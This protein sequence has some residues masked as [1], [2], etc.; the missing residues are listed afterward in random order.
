MGA[1]VPDIV[2]KAHQKDAFTN[3]KLIELEKCMIDPLYFIR[4]YVK[5]Q[6][7]TKGEVPFEPFPYQETMIQT[8]AEYS[9]CIF[10]TGRQQGKT[11]TSNTI[12]RYNN[13]KVKI[14][15][16]I[17]LTFKGKIINFLENILLQLVK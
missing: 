14:K 8:C 3:T 6:H 10:L 7:P 15:N 2:K 12:I 11:F 9:R 4:T 13:T 16:L 5:I 1:G 17:K